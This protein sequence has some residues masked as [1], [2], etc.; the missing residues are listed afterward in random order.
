RA[1]DEET[2][3][4][5]FGGD[6]PYAY[7][8]V[9]AGRGYVSHPSCTPLHIVNLDTLDVETIEFEHPDY[10]GGAGDLRVEGGEIFCANS[11]WLFKIA[12]DGSPVETVKDDFQGVRAMEFSEDL[13]YVADKPSGS[14]SV[15]VLRGSNDRTF[16]DFG[17]APNVSYAQQFR[18]PV[19]ID[20]GRHAVYLLGAGADML[21]V[22]DLETGRYRSLPNMHVVYAFGAD[23][24]Y[25][26][27]AG[28]LQTVPGN[29][30]STIL[31]L[32]KDQLDDAIA[33]ASDQ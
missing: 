18:S 9:K 2:E 7:F 15:S 26:Y 31:R 14:V 12:P 5:E 13:L 3:N 4:I 24:V 27:Y 29:W 17:Q 11:H 21:S 33:A 23:D 32:H 1:F 28:R 22:L 25:L 6:Y 8:E 20:K 19:L 10:G 30:T 16:T